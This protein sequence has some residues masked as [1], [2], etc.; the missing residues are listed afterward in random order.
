LASLLQTFYQTLTYV[1]GC[2]S[3]Q[4][5]N[6]FSSLN[7]FFWTTWDYLKS[8]N[9]RRGVVVYLHTFGDCI[10]RRRRPYYVMKG[11][12]RV[13]VLGPSYF[14]IEDFRTRL[15]DR[16]PEFADSLDDKILRCSTEDFKQLRFRNPLLEINRKF[17]KHHTCN[18]PYE[19]DMNILNK[20]IRNLSYRN[21]QSYWR[22]QQSPKAL[23]RWKIKK[24]TF[25]QSLYSQTYNHSDIGI[26]YKWKLP[27]T[28]RI[29]RHDKSI[30][31]DIPE[32][33]NFIPHTKSLDSGIVLMY[34]RTQCSSISVLESMD[35]LQYP[36]AGPY[37][38]PLNYPFLGENTTSLDYNYAVGRSWYDCFTSDLNNLSIKL[39]YAHLYAIKIK[40]SSGNELVYPHLEYLC[41]TSHYYSMTYD[42]FLQAINLGFL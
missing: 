17:I 35:T 13:R 2:K 19:T 39:E 27:I 22:K 18:N 37:Y 8:K 21:I 31:S 42:V 14:F 6:F 4:L 20:K 41:T 34:D 33:S 16:Y 9:V 36:N 28:N 12:Q 1:L 29:V 23:V 7:I 40:P 25:T 3:N 5:T 15:R 30:L 32:H 11:R 24:L 10:R 38:E 26:V